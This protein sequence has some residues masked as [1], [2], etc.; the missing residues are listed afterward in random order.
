MSCVIF[1]V[2]PRCH[3]ADVQRPLFQRP[4]IHNQRSNSK[5]VGCRMLTIMVICPR[6]VDGTAI[7]FLSVLLYMCLRDLRSDTFG[8]AAS[9]ARIAWGFQINES[10]NANT[11]EAILLRRWPSKLRKT[12]KRSRCSWRYRRWMREEGVFELPW[13]SCSSASHYPGTPPWM[14]GQKITKNYARSRSSW[15]NNLWN[16]FS[17]HDR[18]GL[19]LQSC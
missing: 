6:T 11:V 14:F 2:R 3:F 7:R 8:S 15:E 5:N 18:A 13:L 4:F 16:S 17:G 1:S 10:K 19:F 9:D 12:K